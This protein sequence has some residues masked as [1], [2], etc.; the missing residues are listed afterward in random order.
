MTEP[1][2]PQAQLPAKNAP[3][4]TAKKK[5]LRTNP[6]QSNLL[7]VN[8]VTVTP[9]GVFNENGDPVE[10]SDADRTEVLKVAKKSRLTLIDEE[11]ES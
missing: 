1:K 10:L 5:T 8:G 11:V 3:V 7:H 2:E 6:L 4:A 9:E